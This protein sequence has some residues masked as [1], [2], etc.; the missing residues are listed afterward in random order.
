VFSVFLSCA[1]AQED[2]LA[3]ELYDAGTAGIAEEL[4]GLRAFFED[5]ETEILTRFA[6]FDPVLRREDETDWAAV[7]RDSFPP[8]EIGERWFLAPPWCEDAT[9]P[10]RIRLVINP[11]MACGTGWHPC[12]QLCLESLEHAVG[13]G[14]MVL[15]VGSGSG[16]LSEAA[17]LLGAR[18]VIA[19]DIDGEVLPMFKGS[20]EAVRTGSVDVVVANISA[21]AVEDLHPELTRVLKAG[22]RLIVSGFEINDLPPGFDDC[23]QL[24]RDG[25]ACLIRES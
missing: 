22:G 17:R 15:D 16:I 24:T 7:S 5:G 20:A 21:P 3:A 23:R 2:E 6:A 4:G 11:G 25:W 10:G 12:T 14:D 9:P 8:L 19:C 1:P 13:P 18:T